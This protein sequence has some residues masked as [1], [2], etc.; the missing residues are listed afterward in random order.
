[1]R[2]QLEGAESKEAQMNAILFARM[3]DRMADWH[4]QAGQIY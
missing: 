1:M 4:R 2:R 3:A